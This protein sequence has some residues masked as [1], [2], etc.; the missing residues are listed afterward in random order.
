MR[1]SSVAFIMPALVLALIGA[2]LSVRP[3]RSASP[4]DRHIVG[5]YSDQR[6]SRIKSLTL[7]RIFLYNR[8]GSLI[9]QERWPSELQGFR[10]HA[11]EAFCCVSDTPP[12][13]GGSGPPPDCKIMVYGTDVRGNFEDLFNSSS[14]AIRYHS[15]P[16]HKYLLVE[17][18]ATWCQPCVAG[19]KVLEAF[20]NSSSKAKDYLWVSIDMSRLPE[21]QDA[22]RASKH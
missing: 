12:P 16:K 7:P 19:R 6:L 17:Y 22:A 2:P 14:Q 20:F 21:L 4:S 5:T 1:T 13:P 10:A 11:G 18:Y 15:L 8:H 9:T 3:V